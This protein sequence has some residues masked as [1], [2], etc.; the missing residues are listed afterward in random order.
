LRS[1]LLFCA[2][3][4]VSPVKTRQDGESCDKCVNNVQELAVILQRTSQT[5]ISTARALSTAQK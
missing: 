2:P 4:V 5:N 3:A 1:G